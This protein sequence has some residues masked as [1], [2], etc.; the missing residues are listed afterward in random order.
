[1]Q[2]SRLLLKDV[3]LQHPK[4]SLWSLHFLP[5]VHLDSLFG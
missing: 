5:A 1:M 2:V 3:S 4:I